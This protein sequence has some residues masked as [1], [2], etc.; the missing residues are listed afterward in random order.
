VVYIEFKQGVYYMQIP[1]INSTPPIHGAG[2]TPEQLAKYF[3]YEINKEVETFLNPNASAA[4][5]KAAGMEI[6]QNYQKL[7]QLSPLPANIQTLVNNLKQ[8][9]GPVLEGLKDGTL[10]AQYDLVLAAAGGYAQAA[11][12]SID[13]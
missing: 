6:Y 11:Y 5:K 1:P 7:E 12:D 2:A 3:F 4:D 13:Q 9:Y 10:P 8:N